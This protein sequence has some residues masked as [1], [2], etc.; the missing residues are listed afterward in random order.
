MSKRAFDIAEYEFSDGGLLDIDSNHYA[1]SCWPLVYILSCGKKKQAYVGESTDVLTRIATHLKNSEKSKLKAVHLIS[2]GKFNK[3]AVLDIESNLIRYMAADGQF[4]LLNGNLGLGDHTYYQKAELYW[5]IFTSVWDDLRSKGVVKSSLESIDNSD[6]FKYSPY[7]SL[8]SE[9]EQGLQAILRSLLDDSASR[10]VI[11]G[12][13]GTGKT[14]L[15]IFLFKM[16]ASEQSVVDEPE[17][18]S[19]ASTLQGLVAKAKAKYPNPK[20]ALV[21]P[22]SSFRKTLKKAFRNV[23]GLKANMVIG[24]AEVAKQK[25]DLLLVDESHRLRQRVNLG[26]YFGGFDKAC[27]ALALDK[28]SCTELDWILKQSKKTILFYDE[29][30]SIKPSD[31]PRQNFDR[32][33][34]SD[35]TR[36]E[37]LKSQFRVKGGNAY[38]SF[39]DGLLNHSLQNQAPYQDKQYDLMLFDSLAEMVDQIKQRNS[40]HGLCRLIAGYAWKWIS[41]ND[42]AAFDI[43]IGDVQ[44]KWNATSNDWINSEGSV[45][46]VGC[47]HTTQ[48]YDLNYTGI[49]FGHEIGYDPVAE[50]I[51]IHKENYFDKNGKNSIKDEEELRGFILNIYKTILLRGI[52]GTYVYACDPHLRDYLARYIPVANAQADESRSVIEVLP[53]DQ[54]Q[55]FL[56]AIPLYGLDVAAGGFGEPQ[57]IDEVEWIALPESCPP[58]RDLFACRVVGESMNRVIPNGSI[59]LFRRDPGGSRN[60]K[61]VLVEHSDIYDDDTGS[62]YTVKEYRSK[63]VQ[64]GG[65]WRHESINLKPVSTDSSYQELVLT[66]EGIDEF[67]VVGIFESVLGDN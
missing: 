42:Q 40:E 24:P 39:V 35:R 7:K 10:V 1:K 45:H 66:G 49:I 2:S 11:E 34:R 64:D 48:G 27:E 50:E 20:M 54:V 13:A 9:Q 46:E 15:A 67:R 28:H 57:N 8:S 58:S 33:K 17:Q 25:Y 38:V 37:A 55:P 6:V 32:L 18:D 14:I 21:I 43:V 52:R 16:L 31:A 62:C 60:G 56:N 44:L 22:M 47:I 29:A 36:I 61:I 41:K 19:V 26:A 4:D 51:T 59:C 23:K 63:K 53:H 30:Q 65:S 5:G 12:G 3:S